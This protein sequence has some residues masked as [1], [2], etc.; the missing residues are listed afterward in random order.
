MGKAAFKP[1]RIGVVGLGNFGRL[2]ALTLAGLAEAEL[3]ALVARRQASVDALSAELYAASGRHV[4]G[5]TNLEQAIREAAPVAAPEAA[6][7]A[8]VIASSTCRWRGNC[9]P[10]GIPCWWKSR[11]RVA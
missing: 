4:P 1:V 11:W 8:W 9:W 2:H 5:W 7:E 10:P 3:V 6:P